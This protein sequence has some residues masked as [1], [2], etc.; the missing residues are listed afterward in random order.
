MASLRAKAALSFSAPGWRAPF[1]PK[2]VAIANKS[3][4]CHQWPRRACVSICAKACKR[5]RVWKGDLNSA[6]VTVHSFV[7]HLPEGM[8]GLYHAAREASFEAKASGMRSTVVGGP[9]GCRCRWRAAHPR[10]PVGRQRIYRR[11]GAPHRVTKSRLGEEEISDVSLATFYVFDKENA[12]TSRPIYNLPTTEAAVAA[13][14]AAEAA[15]AGGAAGAAG[16][17]AAVEAAG[18][19]GGA[20]DIATA[21]LG[22][23]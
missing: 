20:I 23:A 17:A 16:V 4:H 7:E 5:N 14:A 1:G 13:E 6:T 9:P 2:R 19:G 8:G 3:E 21:G 15:E 11:S 18:R 12:G 22:K 10:E